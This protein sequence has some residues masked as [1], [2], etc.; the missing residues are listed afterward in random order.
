MAQPYWVVYVGGAYEVAI[1]WSCESLVFPFEF[2][3]I[4]A[5]TPQIT[6]ATYQATAAKLKEITGYEPKKL[7]LTAQTGCK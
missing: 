7:Q 2:V 1:V 4:L 6:S 5:R 3:W